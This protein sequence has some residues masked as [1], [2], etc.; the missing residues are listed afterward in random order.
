MKLL[1]REKLTAARLEEKVQLLVA[2]NSGS[3]EEL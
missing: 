3:Q 1:Q 2:N